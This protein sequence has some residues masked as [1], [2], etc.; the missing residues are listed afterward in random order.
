M[1]LNDLACFLYGFTLRQWIAGSQDAAEK[2]EGSQKLAHT[3]LCLRRLP[4][5]GRYE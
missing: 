1:R 2:A 5:A 4:E 3:L